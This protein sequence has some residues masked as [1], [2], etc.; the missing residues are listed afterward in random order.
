MGS[1]LWILLGWIVC[2]RSLGLTFLAP[3]CCISQ[4]QP[5]CDRSVPAIPP[6]NTCLTHCRVL[7]SWFPLFLPLLIDMGRGRSCKSF[8]WMADSSLHWEARGG[9]EGWGCGG[10]CRPQLEPSLF[11][12]AHLAAIL[13][14]HIPVAAPPT[15]R[16][17]A[18]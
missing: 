7:A 16:A 17:S 12:L 14:Q 1:L 10:R 9:G 5:L 3:G 2:F 11:S 6:H 15:G 8:S 18:L 13:M 4:H